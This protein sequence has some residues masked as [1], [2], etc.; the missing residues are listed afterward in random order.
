MANAHPRL[1]SQLPQA[2]TVASNAQSGVAL[3]LRQL[4]AL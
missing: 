4:F 3:H 1:A 2:Q